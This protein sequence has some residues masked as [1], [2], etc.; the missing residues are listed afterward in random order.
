MLSTKFA[1]SHRTTVFV[2][3]FLIVIVGMVSY[4]SLP[5]EAAPD[6]KFP[7]IIVSTIYPGVSPED[8]EN[9][10]TNR[11]ESKFEDLT[12]LDEM[13]ST[14]SEG[15]SVVVLKFMPD[16]NSSEAL[17]QVRD[18]VNRAQT[19]MPNEIEDPDVREI[20]SSDWPILMVN[21]SGT[22]G[23]VR[24][25]RIAEDLKTDIEAMKGVL[26]VDISGGLEREIRV[27][28]NPH[29]LQAYGLSLNDV[30]NA[31]AME[32]VNIPGGPIKE[33]DLRYTLRIPEEITD[34]NQIK[35]M[36]V[37]TKA[38]HP[39]RVKEIAEVVDD[40]KEK[41]TV[42]RYR[43]VEGVTLTVK[44]ESGA[45]IIEVVDGVK[46]YIDGASKTFPSGTKVTYLSDFS[47]RIRDMI[48][49]LENNIITAL[50]LVMLVL[51]MFIGGRNAFFVALAVPL[52]MLVSFTV[53]SIMGITLNM[54]VLFGLILALGMLVDNAIVIVENIYRH[55]HMDKTLLQAAHDG[56]TE[57]GWPVITS[58]LTTLSVFFPLLAW[59]GIMGE[60]MSYLP[61]TLII[62]LTSSLFV[63]L[64]INPVI[65]SV[66]MKVKKNG[67]SGDEDEQS[68]APKYGVFV[69]GYR[70]ALGFSLRH[71]VVI[72][73]IA[74]VT[75][76]GSMA[77]FILSK[78]QV[79][80]FPS[81]TPERMKVNIQAPEGTRLEATDRITMQVESALADVDNA[82][83]FLSEVG[84]G[85]GVGQSQ[86]HRAIVSV[87]FQDRQD[88]TESPFQTIENLREAISVI[89]GAQIRVEKQ[90]NG[91]PRSAPI[92]IE[93]AGDDYDVLSQAAETVK[94]RINEVKGLGSPGVVASLQPYLV[95]QAHLERSS[96][97]GRL[98]ANGDLRNHCNAVPDGRRGIRRHRSTPGQIP[99]QP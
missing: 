38:G 64:I 9:L 94:S 75:L 80:F 25:K 1:L 93:L 31:L 3:A 15:M 70:K 33:G 92:N 19:E 87:D 34:P 44:K 10:V 77:L 62:T 60:F 59:P 76:A 72:L 81:T 7:Y 17:Q 21:I 88:W 68:K 32:N 41:S 51:F 61:L 63:A 73:L 50:I 74:L 18:R 20:S 6:I 35:N 39:I 91:P 49:E 26:E 54:V 8:I 78:P 65:A 85:G 11:L 5:R 36:V 16:V 83:H 48:R 96:C 86:T 2:L 97:R 69:G 23:L 30:V 46:E 58:T 13:T 98:G 28:V 47:K 42:S 53:L 45:N 89:P 56:T 71:P 24:L 27:E 4:L 79:E 55:A 37:S 66:F 57:V 90:Q 29:S 67:E 43:Q 82:K 99:N 12:D 14:S 84:T 40:F 22:A 52:S 95:E